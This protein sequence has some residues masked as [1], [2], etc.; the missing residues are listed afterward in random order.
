[1][2][3]GLAGRTA[4]VCG[5]SR[6]LGRACAESLAR[7]GVALVVNGRTEATVRAAADELAAAHD[8]PVTGVT[9]DIDTEAGRAA[10]LEAC[11]AP[12]IL[13]T[14]NAGPPPMSFADAT[15]DAWRAAL[16]SNLLAA[17]F[18]VQAVL[19]GMRERRF[20][21]IV[22]ITSAMVMSP[23]PMMVLS[24]AARTGLTGAMK[25]VSRDAVADN[26]TINNILPERIDTARQ[27]Q[28]ADLAVAIKGITLDEAYA[29]IAS[30]IAAGR[31]G[32]PD[33]VGDACA[34]LCS[35]QAGFI[36]GQ[37]LRLDGGS[38]EG[39]F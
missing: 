17:L 25:A 34:Y 23:H 13:V 7:E 22:N 9:A 38:Y 14:N 15:P 27:R 2:D 12:D 28:M 10:L 6:G 24:V 29:E 18:L 37:N 21:R 36:A 1:M 16:E 5:S 11:P 30:T 26:V 31:L 35:A 32:R 8:V 4:I 33:E 19:P 39:V 20:G 3:L